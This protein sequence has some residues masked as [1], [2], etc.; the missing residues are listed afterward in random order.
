LKVI[1]FYDYL[2]YYKNLNCSLERDILRRF[3]TLS[4]SLFVIA[5]AWSARL[6]AAQPRALITEA[7][8]ESK[9]VT[10]PGNTRPE[11]VAANDRG[12][13]ADAFALPVMQL[14][15]K[16]SPEREAAFSARIDELH[17]PHSPNFHQWMTIGQIREE[18]G[19]SPEDI[20]KVSGWLQSHGFT[21]RSVFENGTI[22]HFTGTAGQVREAFHTEIHNIEAGGKMHFANVSDP[23]IP[24]ALAAGVHGVTSLHNF[25]PHP[26]AVNHVKPAESVGSGYNVLSPADIA[27]IYNFNPLYTSGISGKGQTIVVLED[28]NLYSA[29]DWAVYRKTFGLTRKFPFASLTQEQPSGSTTCGNPGSNSNDGEAAIDV[30]LSSAAAPNAAIVLASCSDS[31]EFGGFYA[32]QN[33]IASPTPPPIISISYGESEAEEGAT[34]NLYIYD[35]YQSAVA[36]GISIFVSSG[37]EGADSRDANA[38]Y[39]DHGIGVSGFTS[40]PFNVSVGGTD[41]GVY[42][43]NGDLDSIY[44]SSTNTPAYESALSYIPEIPWNDSCAGAILSAYFG[45]ATPYGSTGFCNSSTASSDGYITTAAGSGGPSNCATGKASTSG[46]SNGTCAGWPKPSWQ[47]L[48]GNPSDGVRDVPDVSLFAANGV[49]GSFYVV[50]WSDPKYTADGSASCLAAP[51]PIADPASW[52]GFGGTSCSTPIMAGIQALVNENTGTT[53]GNPNPTL[54]SLAATEYGSSGSASCNSTLGYATAGT[55][56]FYDVTQGD[57]AID[58][59]KNSKVSGSPYNCYVPSGTYGVLSTSNSA[60]QPAYSAT[61]GWDFATGIGTVNAYNLVMGWPQ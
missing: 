12:R 57:N 17:D 58:C 43:P 40:T 21:V 37:D 11:A 61:T 30:E 28:T 27:V 1:H 6:Q 3:A 25:M 56:L 52:S 2:G 49:W 50:C 60:Y 34:T 15:L 42:A 24:A 45:F 31:T 8:D 22:I 39:G 54:Y 51:N 19:T 26:M 5:L 59:A 29:G 47:S 36:E 23:Q 20:A 16:R 13:V 53:W 55:C 10:L 7:I 18:F 9:L 14:L 33:L 44:F 35:L 4:L 48:L 46:V 41:F 38:T 32:L